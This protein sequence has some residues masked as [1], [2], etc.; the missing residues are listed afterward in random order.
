MRISDWSSDV[1]SSDLLTDAATTLG[2]DGV[3]DDVWHEPAE[4]FD[5]KALAELVGAIAM[6]NL[7][8]RVAVPT[9]STPLNARSRTPPWRDRRSP[10]RS[11]PTAPGSSRSPTGSVGRLPSPRQG[12][13]G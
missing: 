4:H 13:A 5:E 8:N 10:T 2:P 9:R 11:K 12:R 3:P 1:C 7:W 6:I